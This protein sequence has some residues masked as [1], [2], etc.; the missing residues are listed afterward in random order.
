MKR[1]LFSF[2]LGLGFSLL[3]PKYMFYNSMNRIQS[4]LNR[5]HVVIDNGD[6]YMIISR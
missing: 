5:S 6:F 1:I 2:G 3:M 4:F